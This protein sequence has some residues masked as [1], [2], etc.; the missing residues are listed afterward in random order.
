MVHLFQLGDL[1]VDE[2]SC[3]DV[4]A[5][6]PDKVTVTSTSSLLGLEKNPGVQTD[7][8]EAFVAQFWGQELWE[9]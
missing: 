2:H 4:H 8:L 7:V 5:T 6:M 3:A 1:L 9:L